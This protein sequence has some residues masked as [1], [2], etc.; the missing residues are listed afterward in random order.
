MQHIIKIRRIFRNKICLFSLKS[1]YM[2]L[3]SYLVG[4]Q[5]IRTK[6]DIRGIICL[7]EVARLSSFVEPQEANGAHNSPLKSGREV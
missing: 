2:E 5:L 7:F 6:S 4:Y 3:V 1:D